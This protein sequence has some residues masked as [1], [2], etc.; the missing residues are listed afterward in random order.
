M[1]RA[2]GVVQCI[3]IHAFCARNCTVMH[4][5]QCARLVRLRRRTT[6]CSRCP[7][8]RCVGDNSSKYHP[9]QHLSHM[10]LPPSSTN[11]LPPSLHI[12]LI[13]SPVDEC[14]HSQIKTPAPSTYISSHLKDPSPS[15]PS[16][17]SPLKSNNA[18]RLPVQHHVPSRP[19]ILVL[20]PFHIPFHTVHILYLNDP[21]PAPASAPRRPSIGE[22]R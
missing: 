3:W 10:F 13:S 8:C 5:H 15:K 16:K 12:S 6:S 18:I 21:P 22:K 7:F 17:P 1:S 9:P 14:Q 4:F 2:V 11:P 19:I 20:H